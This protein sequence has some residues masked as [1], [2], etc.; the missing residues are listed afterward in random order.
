MGL[1]EKDKIRK[2][3]AEK[4]Q[5]LIVEQCRVDA[6]TPGFSVPTKYDAASCLQRESCYSV[7][8]SPWKEEEEPVRGQGRVWRSGEWDSV[9]YRI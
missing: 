1:R 6:G 8:T 5:K 2:M 3:S 9:L 4:I 7:P